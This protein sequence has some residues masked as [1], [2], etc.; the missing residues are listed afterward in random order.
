MADPKNRE[1]GLKAA[2]HNPRVSQEAKDHDRDLLASEFG[3]TVEETEAVPKRRS[4]SS[5]KKSSS[6]GPHSHSSGSQAQQPPSSGVDKGHPAGR[7]GRRASVGETGGLHM[8]EEKD[9]GNVIRGLK[10]A[11]KNP[12]VSEQAKEADRKKLRDLG[13]PAE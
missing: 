11:L 2:L 3:E 4:S 5:G 6:T 12:N 1:R 13:E 7:K 8:A 9:R 10:A